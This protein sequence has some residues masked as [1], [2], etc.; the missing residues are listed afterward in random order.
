VNARLLRV[1]I[2]VA[3]ERCVVQLL[4]AIRLDPDDLLDTG[5]ADTREA[6]TRSRYA[7]LHVRYV[8]N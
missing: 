3:L 6:D 2:D 4:L 1:E 7:R 8:D 5:D